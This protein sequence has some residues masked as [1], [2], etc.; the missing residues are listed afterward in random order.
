MVLNGL[1]FHA[2][3]LSVYLID[4]L[5]CGLTDIDNRGASKLKIDR[6]LH[7]LHLMAR[8]RVSFSLDCLN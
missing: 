3:R 2:R 7:R 8:A 6:K 1:S 5:C 4:S